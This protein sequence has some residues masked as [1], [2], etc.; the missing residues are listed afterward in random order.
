MNGVAGWG[1]TLLQEVRAVTDAE[2]FERGEDLYSEGAVV[3]WHVEPGGLYGFVEG[4]SSD[5][6]CT[7]RVEPLRDDHL[8]LLLT[9]VRH[10][11]EDQLSRGFLE[12][13]DRA[14]AARRVTLGPTSAPGPRCECPDWGEY[15]RHSVALAHAFADAVSASPWVWL[16]AR[17][18]EPRAEDV[19]AAEPTLDEELATFWAGTEEGSALSDVPRPADRERDRRVLVEALTAAFRTPGRNRAAVARL[20]EEAAAGFEELYAELVG[21]CGEVPPQSSPGSTGTR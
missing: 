13:L 11:P 18:L 15:C 4:R 16:H 21:R 8:A 12:V 17:G 19:P 5:Y 1:D 10:L 7:L 20:A 6:S 3:E 14:L 2:R 9:F